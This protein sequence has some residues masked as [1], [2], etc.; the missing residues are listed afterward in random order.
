MTPEL[1]D[2]LRLSGA[3]ARHAAA[4]QQIAAENIANADTPGYRAR[5]LPGFEEVVARLGTGSLR[6]QID[7]SVPVSPNGNAVSLETEM[8]RLADIRQDHDLAL[9]VYRSALD[10]LRTGLGR[11]A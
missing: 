5:D 10:I 11:R 1:P 8:L 3:L 6:A 2:L 4:R 9:G 7:R